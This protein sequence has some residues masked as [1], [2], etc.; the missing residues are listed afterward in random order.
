MTDWHARHRFC[1]NCGQPTRA[2]SG[3]WKRECDGC[4]AQ[5]FP[6]TDPV[7]IMLVVRHDPALG[8]V[9]LMARQSRFPPGMYSCIAGF[10]EPGESFEDAVRRETL[11]ETGLVVGS[12]R[13]L[14]CQP[15]P[16]PS[17]LM[18]GCIAES[19]TSAITLDETEL[20]AGR[21]FTRAEAELMLEGRHPEGF[22][23]PV[24]IAIANTLLR[25]WLAM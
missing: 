8:D 24:H 22:T 23:P 19:L 7:T 10:V 15:W 16:F 5:H 12:V 17:S 3:G 11:E 18:I 13:Y 6:R 14:A 9:C 2:A 4:G 21:W 1:A 25:A 20:E